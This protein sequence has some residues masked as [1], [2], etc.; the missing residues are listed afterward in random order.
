MSEPRRRHWPGLCDATDVLRTR[1]A[2]SLRSRLDS[3]R[4]SPRP[5]VGVGKDARSQV[6]WKRAGSGKS[7]GVR[8]IYFNLTDEEAV[9][10]VAV[11]AAEQDNMLPKDIRKVV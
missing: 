4:R 11:Y 1:P 8:V 3:K 2:S 7:G 6:R 5:V 10:L 9:L